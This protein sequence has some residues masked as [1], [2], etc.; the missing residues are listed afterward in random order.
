MCALCP[1]QVAIAP[2]GAEKWPPPQL[3][4]QW[5]VAQQP[6]CFKAARLNSRCL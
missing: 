5:V 6:Q 2:V 1:L 3:V 4:A